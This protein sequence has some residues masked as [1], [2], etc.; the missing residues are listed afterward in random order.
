MAYL[1]STPNVIDFLILIVS[2]LDLGGVIAGSVSKIGR[3]L[4]PLKLANHIKP[5]REMLE[6][7]TICSAFNCEFMWS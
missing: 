2:L 4:R 6:V 7:G 5:V 3:A 1:K